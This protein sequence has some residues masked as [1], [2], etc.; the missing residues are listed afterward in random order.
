MTLKLPRGGL[1]YFTKLNAKLILVLLYAFAQVGVVWWYAA[2]RSSQTGA[3]AGG[4]A[5]AN[6]KIYVAVE[7]EGKIAVINPQNELIKYID[8]SKTVDGMKYGFTAHNVQVAPDGR[9]VWVTA[10]FAAG[11]DHSFNP[12]RLF[13]SLALG[14]SGKAYA[15]GNHSSSGEEEEEEDSAPA[16]TSAQD[17]VIVIDPAT[18]KII[19][20]LAL[21]NDLHLA[22]I[23]LTPDS[24]RAYASAQTKDKIYQIDAAGLKLQKEISL[25]AGSGPHGIRIAPDGALAYVALSTGK[26]IGVINLKTGLVAYVELKGQAVQTGVTPDG[27]WVVASV[28]DAKSLAVYD[29]AQKSLRYI[30]LPAEAKG[31]IQMYATPDSRYFYL[32]DQGY[33]FNQPSSDKVYKVDL[34]GFKVVATITAGGAPHGVVVSPDGQKTYV[35]N[36]L[37]GDLS[38]INNATGREVSRLKIGKQP[39]GVS[40]WTKEGGGTP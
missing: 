20:R 39:N 5:S 17:E 4:F 11:D 10:N 22:H 37:S 40:I 25:R 33:Y 1:G 6:Q 24:K 14:L 38:V 2:A 8:L 35:T 32:A 3:P 21:G 7:E 30:D 28:Y 9:S 26:A 13:K 29:T 19:Q 18:D 34:A 31:P 23:V 36:L 12:L 15:S 16:A 27:R